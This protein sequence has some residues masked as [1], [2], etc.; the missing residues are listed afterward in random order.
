MAISDAQS[1]ATKKYKASHIKHINFECQI[2]FYDAIKAAADAQ[3]KGVN[4]LIKDALREYL[5][6]HPPGDG[7]GGY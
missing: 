6:N 3:G 7:V 5:A 4:T 2:S 1:R